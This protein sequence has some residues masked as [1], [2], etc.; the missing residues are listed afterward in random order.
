MARRAF[1]LS[2]LTL[3]ALVMTL[4]E[5]SVVP[6]V[7][8]SSIISPGGS[9]RILVTGAKTAGGLTV[10]LVD[11]SEGNPSS[12]TPVVASVNAGSAS[13]SLVVTLSVPATT[14][15]TGSYSLEL[16]HAA[17]G[18]TL[19]SRPVQVVAGE[20]HSLDVASNALL[21]ETDK[22]VYKPGQTVKIRVLS[23]T[24]SLMPKAGKVKVTVKDPRSFAMARWAEVEVDAYGVGSVQFPTSTEP[25]LGTW[26]VEAEAVEAA[27]VVEGADEVA[28][29]VKT[30]SSF[31]MDRYVLPTFEVKVVPD[32]RAVYNGQSNVAGVV[33]AAYTYGEPLA[34]GSTVAVNVWQRTGGGGG[35]RH[36]GG[37]A[38]DMAAVR[39]EAPGND[40]SST[41]VTQETRY[42]LVASLGE[43]P[44]SGGSAPFTLDVSNA[45]INF[46]YGYG[47][48]PEL[49]VEA[50][51]TDGATGATQ[52]GT[53][54]LTPAYTLYNL[55][56]KG[57]AGT[58]AKPGLGAALTLSA[59]RYDGSPLAAT[60]TMVKSVSRRNGRTETTSFEVTTTEVTTRSNRSES[61]SFS[62]GAADETTVAE[63]SF[64]VQVPADDPTCCLETDDKMYRRESCCITG[65]SVSNDR[66]APSA[67]SV[68]PAEAAAAVAGKVASS[69]SVPSASWYGT[70]A[71]S[72]VF[73]AYVSIAPPSSPSSSSS[74]QSSGASVSFEVTSTFAPPAGRFN[75]AVIA[76]TAGVVASGT[77]TSAS[78]SSTGVFQS[79]AVVGITE[80]MAP[81]ANLLVFSPYD[82]RGGEAV[83]VVAA[84]VSFRVK[85]STND[86]G[87][88]RS[89]LPQSCEVT[90]AASKEKVRPGATV[91]V[92]ATASVPGSRVFFLA[93]DVSV[94]LHA[95][96]GGGG[97]SALTA[98]RALAAV[99][100]K[101]VTST[102][103]DIAL[104]SSSS[105]W[106]YPPADVDGA[107]IAVITALKTSTCDAQSQVLDVAF[108]GGVGPGDVMMADAAAEAMPAMAG[109][110]SKSA[111]SSEGGG[112]GGGGDAGLASVTRVRSFFPETWIWLDA[113]SDSVSGNVTLSGIKAPDTITSWR[114]AAFATH[115]TGGLGVADVASLGV[116][117]P[118]FV[119][120]NLPFSAT[121]GEDLVVRVGVFN[122]LEAP[123]V[124]V[125]ELAESPADYDVVSEGSRWRTVNVAAK[126]TGAAV[127]AVRPKRLGDVA[128]QVSGRT[129][130]EV[131]Y[132]DAVRKT[133]RVEPEGFPQE[134]VF[135]VVVNRDAS[136]TAPGSEETV[137]IAI[138]PLPPSGVVEGSVRAVLSVVGD[139]MGPSIKGLE[140]LVRVPTGCGEQN[141]IGM[142]PNVYVLTYLRQA[143]QLLT[144]ELRDRAASNIMARLR[145]IGS[146]TISL[147]VFVPVLALDSICWWK[148][149]H[150]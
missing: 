85:L 65:I 34:D 14:T 43:R 2:T 42:A 83:N 60:F 111:S 120:P 100:P 21:I 127:F 84:Q 32:S 101:P 80:E 116:F 5:A 134:E 58:V 76:G 52:N 95:G 66:N 136:S 51:V 73:G 99:A 44:M 118:F 140:R 69:S 103:E 16:T 147:S 137:K 146:V 130:A 86:T 11:S 61:V 88:A 148:K 125:V 9:L 144:D 36:G 104:T 15:T 89:I 57:V 94:T 75:W 31:T 41:Q 68:A 121:R 50:F 49:V 22:K 10:R 71:S 115:P 48:A 145:R 141:M 91:S 17:S 4:A 102:G 109:A 113:A 93:Y 55:D 63:A 117:K 133:V 97:A 119:S 106:C 79:F 54:A 53:A 7:V 62:P 74:V 92:D 98:E 12:V 110:E 112:G 87:E 6:L 24:P 124:V 20:T 13:D 114:F 81:A 123:L 29:V 139:L 33:T 132:A 35:G 107:V 27:E 38:G 39:L 59:T 47:Q 129:V 19:S 143:R 122:Y 82:G 46:G 78:A 1:S 37:L 18:E 40:A 108:D 67:V 45:K 8:T 77:T 142:A 28:A 90:V 56:L 105:S 3:A 26:T 126:G 23:L 149:K 25:T 135:N 30:S 128:V 96:S 131:G 138:A 150:K 72:T 64:A 70:I